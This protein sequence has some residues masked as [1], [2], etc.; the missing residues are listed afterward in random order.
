MVRKKKVENEAKEDTVVSGEIKEEKSE[1]ASKKSKSGNTTLIITEKPAAAEKIASA[2]SDGKDR[3]YSDNGVPFY[4]FEKNGKRVVVGCAVGH[5]FGI[6]EDKKGARAEI[7]SFEVIWKPNFETKNKNA[8]FTKKYYL[9]LKK[10]SKE[11]NEFIVATDYDIE[12]EV[13]GWNV[14]RFISGQKDAKRMKF[15]SLTKDELL[16]AY[17]NL[18]PT[19]NW[20]QAYAGETRHYVDWFYG[21]N[22]SRALMRSLS[23]AKAFRIMSVGRVQGPALAIVVDKELQIK[24]FKP[25]PYWQVFLQ[26]QDINKQKLEVKYPKDL[27]KESELTKFRQLKGKKGIAKTE[28]KDEQ[29]HPPVPFDLTTLQTEAY[30]FLGLTPTQ[31]LQI[32]QKLYLAGLI[33]GDLSAFNI[34][35]FNEKPCLIDFSQSTLITTPNWKEL[36]HRDIKNV[37]Q[38]FSNKGIDAN[39][40]DIFKKVTGKQ[41]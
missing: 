4:E 35:N 38:F 40:E 7:P 10:L 28:I 12:G 14:V 15:S 11:A 30:K 18:S 20:G 5:L 23:K 36:L 41:L 21:I 6:A 39:P 32:A 1:K 17:D 3:K 8:G 24:S 34:L 2:L 16:G 31:S 27:T 26:I 25:E 33:H 9:L 13:I 37:L 19:I 29:I 22:L